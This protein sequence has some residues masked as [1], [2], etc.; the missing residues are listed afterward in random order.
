[1]NKGLQIVIGGFI[2]IAVAA[3]IGASI[4]FAEISQRNSWQQTNHCTEA[5][6]LMLTGILE[7]CVKL[8][9]ILK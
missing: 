8:V 3:I 1:M 5:G 2:L 9:P 6:G 4:Y 7:G